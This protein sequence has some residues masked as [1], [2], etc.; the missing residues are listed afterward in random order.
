[1]GKPLQ[2][3]LFQNAHP[4]GEL[5]CPCGH[6]QYGEYQSLGYEGWLIGKGVKHFDYE[7]QKL[8]G[9]CLEC[10]MPGRRMDKSRWRFSNPENEATVHWLARL[11]RTRTSADQLLGGIMD[12][13]TQELLGLDKYKPVVGDTVEVTSEYIWWHDK[14]YPFQRFHHLDRTRCP[15]LG[16]ELEIKALWLAESYPVELQSP[17]GYTFRCSIEH[18]HQMFIASSA[19]VLE[20]KNVLLSLSST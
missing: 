19:T 13:Y 3:L 20:R 17:D 18:C 1:M 16:E 11:A 14:Y 8:I 12:K 10:G 2:F 15:V 6:K 7:G 4:E 5:E 9:V